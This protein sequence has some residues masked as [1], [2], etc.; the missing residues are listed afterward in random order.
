MLIANAC[1]ILT[2]AMALW[3]LFSRRRSVE[4]FFITALGTVVGVTAALFSI[5]VPLGV[6]LFYAAV[7]MLPVSVSITISNRFVGRRLGQDPSSIAKEK[8]RQYLDGESG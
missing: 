2:L 8:A 6:S 3:M 5:G 1:L 7:G 4:I